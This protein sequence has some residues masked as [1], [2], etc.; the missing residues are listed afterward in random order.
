[1]STNKQVAS[2]LVK[3]AK[4]VLSSDKKVDYNNFVMVMRH[5]LDRSILD[6]QEVVNLGKKMGGEYKKEAESF[7]KLLPELKRCSE[8]ALKIE[9]KNWPDLYSK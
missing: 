1:M 9:K 7:G 2:Q 4:Q 6:I 8:E 5:S 3:L